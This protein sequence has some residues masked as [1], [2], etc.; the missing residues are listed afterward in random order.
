MP[1]WGHPAFA[2]GKACFSDHLFAN[3]G[4]TV[5]WPARVRHCCS[6]SHWI[7]VASGVG[8]AINGMA[9]VILEPIQI[10]VSLSADIAAIGLV[11]LHAKRAWVRMVCFWIYD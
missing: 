8:V 11:L 1:D 7:C 6:A 2:S 5:A 4:E 9:F 3:V 10:L